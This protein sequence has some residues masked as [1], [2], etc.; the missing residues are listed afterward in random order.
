MAMGKHCPIL[1]V[2]GFQNSGK[3]TLME[4]LISRA[5]QNGLRSATIKHHG[6][7]G[8]PTDEVRSKDSVRHHKAGA[9]VSGVEGNGIL[10]LFAMLDDWSLEKLI[11]FYEFFSI[12]VL[13][14][15]GYKKEHYPKVV[16]IR[17]ENDLSLLHSLTNIQCIISH[18]R[19][20]SHI[21]K[22]YHVFHLNDDHLYLDFLM[23]EVVKKNGTTFI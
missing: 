6:H 13:F 3:T 15:E 2:V 4:K 11:T 8:T 7:G 14:I 16:L 18:R 23:E 12:D 19:V 22:D 17:D 20:D 5:K 9:I 10:Q 1:Q 21:L